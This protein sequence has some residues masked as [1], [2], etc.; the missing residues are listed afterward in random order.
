LIGLT[1]LVISPDKFF[2]S[3]YKRSETTINLKNNKKNE[4]KK[5]SENKKNNK[6]N[7]IKQKKKYY[8]KL[9]KGKILR[10]NRN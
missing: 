10:A 6:E 3:N 8:Y 9:I 1:V 5:N 2:S 4:K 7:K